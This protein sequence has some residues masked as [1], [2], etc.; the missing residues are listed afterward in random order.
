MEA[1]DQILRSLDRSSDN[2]AVV[3]AA[4]DFSKSFSRCAHNR[5]LESYINVGASQWLVDMHVSFLMDWTMS[6]KIGT[7]I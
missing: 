1:W 4:V 2:K 5:I 3:F 6:V 7:H